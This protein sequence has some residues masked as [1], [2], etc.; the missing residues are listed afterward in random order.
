MFDIK[1]N[2]LSGELFKIIN[3]DKLENSYLEI[4][5]IFCNLNYD[6]CYKILNNGDIIFTDLY[7]L[8]YDK[9]ELNTNLII[10]FLSYY[11][12]FINKL[13]INYSYYLIYINKINNDMDIVK[14]VMQQNT[15]ALKYASN[16]LKYDINGHNLEYASNGLKK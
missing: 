5:N 16:R 3:I 11:K 6:K 14:C 13:K 10:I 2:Q 9:V 1:I 8:D 12:E 4:K 7:D 15:T